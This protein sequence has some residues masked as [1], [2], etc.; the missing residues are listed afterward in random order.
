[1]ATKAT[2]STKGK[3]LATTAAQMPAFM[4][5]KVG[6]GRGNE[7]IDVSDLIIPRLEIVQALSPCKQKRDP[8]YIEDADDGMLYNNVTRELYGD[9]VTVL[10]IY[11]RKEY[12]V[13][14]DRKKSDGAGFRGSY[15]TAELAAKKIEEL[16]DES[17]L[18]I[19][20]TAQQFCILVNG[21]KWEDIVLSMAR[22]KMKIARRWNSQIKLF[23]GDRFSRQYKVESM[24][25]K[26][27]KGTFYNFAISDL[28]YVGSEKLF[29]F[30]EYR[31]N[32]IKGGR[33]AA[34][35]S[36]FDAGDDDGSGHV[37]RGGD[38]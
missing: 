38:F 13:W 25:E 33:V 23:G 30:A 22:S 34:D 35:T 10:P 18:Q 24:E 5:G 2:Q 17:D 3:Q 31:Y 26:G 1:M 9:S 6:A 8:Q 21:D 36:G 15:P 11:F 29:K 20:D 12:L 4:Q 16:D 7:N 28:G 27:K 32:Q 14:V 19:V 37:N